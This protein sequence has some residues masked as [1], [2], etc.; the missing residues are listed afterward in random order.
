MMTCMPMRMW[1]VTDRMN[2]SMI[3]ATSGELR[4]WTTAA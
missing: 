2:S 3:T 1:V 4:I